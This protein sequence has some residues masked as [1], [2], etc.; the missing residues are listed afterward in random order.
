MEQLGLTAEDGIYQ[1]WYVD[2]NDHLTGG[3]EAVN[4]ACRQIWWLKPLSYFYYLPGFRQLEDRAYRWI[5]E[6]R[7]RFPGSTAA[8]AMPE[9]GDNHSKK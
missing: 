3:A 5:A 8:C 4:Q 6:N 1:A 9:P 7:H 2:D